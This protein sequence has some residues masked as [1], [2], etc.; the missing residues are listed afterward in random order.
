MEK[1]LGRERVLKGVGNQRKLKKKKGSK[2]RKRKWA[3]IRSC[4]MRTKKNKG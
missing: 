1:E 4:I 2:I 3:T